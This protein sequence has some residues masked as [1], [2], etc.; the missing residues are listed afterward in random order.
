MLGINCEVWFW[1][2]LLGHHSRPTPVGSQPSTQIP[3]IDDLRVLFWE[4]FTVTVD[5]NEL[6]YYIKLIQN[7][8][9]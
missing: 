5:K 3:Y 2:N 4:S 7:F 8:L 9:S 6:F 1:R